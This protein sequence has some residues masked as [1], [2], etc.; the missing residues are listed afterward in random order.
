MNYSYTGLH[1]LILNHALTDHSVLVFLKHV[2]P[3]HFPSVVFAG[4]VSRF[5][6]IKR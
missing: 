5:E 3:T 2:V 1:V 4:D 6:H